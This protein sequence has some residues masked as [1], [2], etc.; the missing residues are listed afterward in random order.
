[1]PARPG[2]ADQ[3]DEDVPAQPLP[4]VLLMERNGVVGERRVGM[5]AASRDEFLRWSRSRHGPSRPEDAIGETTT[6]NS[7]LGTRRS[8]RSCVT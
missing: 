8:R 1:M 7:R 6:G 3:N 5:D 4:A 2:K